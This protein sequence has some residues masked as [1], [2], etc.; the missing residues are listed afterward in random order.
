DEYRKQ[1]RGGVG[2]IDLDTK[3]EDFVTNLVTASS[4]A[5]I[6]FFTDKGKAYQIKMY[7]LPEGKRATKGKALVNFLS[8]ADNEKVTSILP[9]PKESKQAAA[10]SLMM[11]TKDGT[12]KKVKA[13]SFHEV[14]RSGL[15]AITLEAGDALM[16]VSFVSKGDEMS[17]VTAEGQSIRFK[18]S[19]IREMGRSA[20]GVRGISLAKGDYVISADVIKSGAKGARIMVISKNGYGKTTE[21]GEYKTQK[22][23]GSGILTMNCTDKTGQVIS[24]KVITED[25]SELV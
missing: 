7:E 6:L 11:V 23:G 13:D 20:M 2:V 21:A 17:I 14:R 24:A 15:I 1:R 22:R 19:D 8:L 16:S 5:D 9:M 10:L 4:H 12:A 18:E 25:D 3:E